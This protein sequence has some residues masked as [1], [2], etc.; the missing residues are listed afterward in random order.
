MAGLAR[1]SSA[2]FILPIK[3]NLNWK[4]GIL[5]D[6]KTKNVVH[7][8]SLFLIQEQKTQHFML[9]SKSNI[10]L[11]YIYEDILNHKKQ[12]ARYLTKYEI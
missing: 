5:P 10:L 9:I 7:P 11:F 3:K 4:Q 12:P 2:S 6:H 1:L 8:A